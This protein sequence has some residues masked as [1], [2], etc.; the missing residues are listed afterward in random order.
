MT[1]T[2]AMHTKKDLLA[3][4]IKKNFFDLCIHNIDCLELIEKY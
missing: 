1:T 4:T 3:Y 2:H